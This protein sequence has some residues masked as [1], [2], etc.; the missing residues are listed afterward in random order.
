MKSERKERFKKGFLLLELLAMGKK[1]GGKKNRRKNHAEGKGTAPKDPTLAD[2]QAELELVVSNAR[3]DIS[4]AL[5]AQYLARQA[6]L[7]RLICCHIDSSFGPCD[8]CGKPG[9]PSQCP[10]CG[11]GY[12][13]AACQKKEWKRHKNVCRD[14]VSN[15]GGVVSWA[16]AARDQAARTAPAEVAGRADAMG[17]VSATELDDML[18]EAKE[19]KRTQER[20]AD[21]EDE[22][23]IL[24]Q[25]GGG[26]GG[27][28]ARGRLTMPPPRNEDILRAL[29][30]R[31]RNAQLLKK[32][33]Q[34]SYQSTGTCLPIPK[35]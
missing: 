6:E 22:R 5:A 27:G 34:I 2:L 26:E 35:P 9:A 11:T 4:C 7:K 25:T 1:R 31:C 17:R 20:Y 23:Q 15:A 18:L 33:S 8:C 29:R 30:A 19:G 3:G 13:D 12:C 24:G 14:K 10:K 16:L 21:L 32:T 28:G